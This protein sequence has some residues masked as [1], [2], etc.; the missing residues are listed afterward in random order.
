MNTYS[1]VTIKFGYKKTP[2]TNIKR[3]PKTITYTEPMELDLSKIKP[4]SESIEKS[5]N[6]TFVTEMR[7]V[8]EI[9]Y[10]SPLNIWR[11]LYEKEILRFIEDRRYSSKFA[12]KILYNKYKILTLLYENMGQELIK[13]KMI[14]YFEPTKSRSYKGKFLNSITQ[15]NQ[16]LFW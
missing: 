10:K 12:R 11:E 13:N 15:N 2:G 5:L 4:Y 6:N 1:K 8:D 16:T 7:I 14:S 9:I 3:K